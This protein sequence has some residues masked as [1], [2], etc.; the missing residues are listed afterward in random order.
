MPFVLLVTGLARVWPVLFLA[1]SLAMES[2]RETAE[3]SLTKVLMATWT[4]FLSAEI[5]SVSLGL[6]LL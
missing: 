3:K 1:L 6:A 4:V 5:L 2:P